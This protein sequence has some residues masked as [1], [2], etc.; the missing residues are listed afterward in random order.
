MLLRLGASLLAAYCL[1]SCSPNLSS[2]PTKKPRVRH[3]DTIGI[4]VTQKTFDSLVTASLGRMHLAANLTVDNCI[5]LVRLYNTISLH[6][7]QSE[8]ALELVRLYGDAIIDRSVEILGMREARPGK[9]YSPA[10][11]VY[12]GGL[13]H[14][15][16]LYAIIK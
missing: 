16:S 2:G 6:Q 9:L 1:Y 3:S 12:F 7:Y 5:V 4:K 13:P 10:H 11:D 15:N 8:Q 14:E